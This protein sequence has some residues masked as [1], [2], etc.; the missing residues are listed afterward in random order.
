[1]VT[2]DPEVEYKVYNKLTRKEPGVFKK[3]EH[4]ISNFLIQ[5]Y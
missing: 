2:T 5:F 3:I 1:M 4:F